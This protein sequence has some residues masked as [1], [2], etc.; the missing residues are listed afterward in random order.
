MSALTHLPGRRASAASSRLSA[1]SALAWSGTTSRARRARCAEPH[2]SRSYGSALRARL[3]LSWAYLDRDIYA[4]L[5]AELAQPAVEITPRTKL[6]TDPDWADEITLTM[7][8]RSDLDS[9]SDLR[10]GG[11]GQ[12]SIELESVATYDERPDVVF[13]GFES[14]AIEGGVRITP[15]G[16]A[17]LTEQPTVPVTIRGTTHNLTP[18]RIGTPA[19]AALRTEERTR[20]GITTISITT[21]PAAQ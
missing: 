18:L 5:L 10:S 21:K 15:Y 16:Q 17:T 12:M 8:T 7:R 6:A 9:I 4:T 11:Y 14:A 2:R 20:R 13:G 19:I 1:P 3:T